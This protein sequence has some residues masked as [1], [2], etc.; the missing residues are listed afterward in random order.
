MVKAPTLGEVI[1]VV[2]ATGSDSG[3]RC[4]RAVEAL[5]STSPMVVGWY[6]D[7]EPQAPLG[8]TGID[9]GVPTHFPIQYD[10]VTLSSR[11]DRHPGRFYMIWCL[12]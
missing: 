1:L 8:D 5:F 2:A 11:P 9:R 12:D 3:Q 10:L 6:R 7:D 4:T